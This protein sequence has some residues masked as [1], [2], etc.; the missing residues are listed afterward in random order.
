MPAALNAANEAAVEGFL[1]RKIKFMDIPEIIKRT[2]GRHKVVKYY[3]L[4][5][6]LT[7]DNWARN[8]ASNLIGV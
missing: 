7:A 4:D 6:I 5:D 3:G 2:M 8:F 1:S